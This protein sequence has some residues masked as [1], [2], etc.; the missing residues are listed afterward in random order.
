MNDYV[1]IYRRD[2]VFRYVSNRCTIEGFAP[3]E[4]WMFGN[5]PDDIRKILTLRAG[6]N[7]YPLHHMCIKGGKYE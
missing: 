3:D 2:D 5:V 1:I 6:L 4:V 7:G